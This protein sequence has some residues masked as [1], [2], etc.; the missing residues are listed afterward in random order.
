MNIFKEKNLDEK[1][2]E[3]I[4]IIDNEYNRAIS[5]IKENFTALDDDTYM[6][7]FLFFKKKIFRRIS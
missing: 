6:G 4:E 5:L 2:S 3:F 1:I 7:K